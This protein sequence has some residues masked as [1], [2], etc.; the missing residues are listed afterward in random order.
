MD[1]VLAF[2]ST[3]KAIAAQAVFTAA[4]RRFALIPTP[5]HI[6]AGCGMSLKFAADSEEAAQEWLDLL[7]RETG[8][9]DAARLYAQMVM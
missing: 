2:E 4:G 6:T 7:M 3:H 9:V 5:R 1:Y 8:D